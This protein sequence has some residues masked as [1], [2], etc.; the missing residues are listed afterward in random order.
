[1]KSKRADPSAFLFVFVDVNKMVNNHLLAAQ[2]TATIATICHAFFRRSAA[3]LS[4]SDSLNDSAT[5]RNRV[6]CC[7]NSSRAVISDSLASLNS[8]ADALNS[9][10][11][12]ALLLSNAS[13][14]RSIVVKL[15]DSLSSSAVVISAAEHPPKTPAA[16]KQQQSDENNFLRVNR[17]HPRFEKPMW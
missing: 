5:V 3:F 17:N 10:L 7:L 9:A 16:S 14:S 15:A 1:M 11:S 8:L 6:S 2:T 13:N 4:R 12:F